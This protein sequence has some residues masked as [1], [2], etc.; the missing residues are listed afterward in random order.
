MVLFYLATDQQGI[1]CYGAN[2]EFMA[3]PE[4]HLKLDNGTVYLRDGSPILDPTVPAAAA[5]WA[6]IP[7]S[8][9]GGSGKYKGAPVSHLIDGV[10]ADSGGYSNVG[11]AT[12]VGAP[13]GILMM[14]S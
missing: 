2:T 7:L 14:R 13:G 11:G 6:S 5:W 1:G 10:L 8:G 3:H 4:W 9:T 12:D